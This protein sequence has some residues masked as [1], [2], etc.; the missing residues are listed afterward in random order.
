MF[1]PMPRELIERS[2]AG[3]AAP[4]AARDRIVASALAVVSRS[5]LA[6]LSMRAVARRGGV[7]VGLAHY[8]FGS[9]RELVREAMGQAR[10]TFLAEALARLPERPE[11]EPGVQVLRRTLELVRA[12]V[13]FLP[14]W[15]RVVAELDAL[16]LRDPRFRAEA[17][18]ARRQAEGDVHRYLVAAL[19][20]AGA[21][22]SALGPMAA[23]LLSAFDGLA[24]RRLLDPSL[25]LD[26]ALLTVERMILATAL[27]GVPPPASPWN[28]DA[29]GVRARAALRA[30]RRR[31]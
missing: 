31:S 7:S 6:G 20:A 13:D 1:N 3:R 11:A 18:A 24:V 30:K 10:H 29:L 23:V 4:P 2:G 9:K 17:A 26:A 16:G 27:P 12:L 28:D 21:D 15:Y 5:G 25:D 8:H 19:A 14:A 22:T